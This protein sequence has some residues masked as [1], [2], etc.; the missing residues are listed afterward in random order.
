MDIPHL[1]TD[2]LEAL[3]RRLER[4][5]EDIHGL[6]ARTAQGTSPSWRGEAADRHRELVA[7]HRADLTA[8]AAAVRDAAAGVRVLAVTAREQLAFL[9]DAAELAWTPRPIPAVPWSPS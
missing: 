1:P 3:A 4:V 8:L 7:R 2:D 5:A 9:Q 6:A